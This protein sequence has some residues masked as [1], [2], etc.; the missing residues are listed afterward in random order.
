[1]CVDKCVHPGAQRVGVHPNVKEMYICEYSEC[2]HAS[3][4]CV[5]L[6]CK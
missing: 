4:Q 2:T 3:T 5:H 6:K 1:M